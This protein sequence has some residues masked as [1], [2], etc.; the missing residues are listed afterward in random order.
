MVRPQDAGYRLQDTGSRMVSL[1]M[2]DTGY[3]MV[4]LWMQVRLEGERIDEL[5]LDFVRK[6]QEPLKDFKLTGNVVNVCVVKPPP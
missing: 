2:Q 1:W 6:A 3:R 4:R 5:S